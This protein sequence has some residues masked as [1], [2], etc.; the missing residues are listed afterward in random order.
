MGELDRH[1]KHLRPIHV[2]R[3]NILR[4]SLSQ[5]SLGSEML[6]RPLSPTGSVRSIGSVGSAV[7]IKIGTHPG[8]PGFQLPMSPGGANGQDWDTQS[9][10][11]ILSEDEELAG[12]LDL[13]KINS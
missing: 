10:S 1:H 8:L 12:I 9:V 5:S 6:G 3:S 11:S 13:D 2:D 4:R 7:S